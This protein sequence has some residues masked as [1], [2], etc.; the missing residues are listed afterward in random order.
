VSSNLRAL[1]KRD[2]KKEIR[3][4][5]KKEQLGER[6]NSPDEGENARVREGGASKVRVDQTTEIQRT[7]LIKGSY[8]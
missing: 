5:E 2:A 4:A 6:K 3:Q 7:L 8:S 1:N